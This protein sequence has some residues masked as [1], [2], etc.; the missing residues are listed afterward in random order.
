M[1]Y[2]IRLQAH[3]ARMHARTRTHVLAYER[4]H[5]A[6][7]STHTHIFTYTH[8]NIYTQL[9]STCS[10]LQ[11]QRAI[12]HIPAWMGYGERGYKKLNIPPNT[13]LVLDVDLVYVDYKEPDNWGMI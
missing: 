10:S 1:K 4:T 13:D 6:H 2:R 7:T 5:I 11:G 3:G 12:V 9:Y 8:V